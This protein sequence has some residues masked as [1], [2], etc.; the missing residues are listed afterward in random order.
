MRVAKYYGFT[1]IELIVVVAII[2]ILSTIVLASMSTSKQKAR[3]VVDLAAVQD[4]QRVAFSQANENGKYPTTND[5]CAKLR[6]VPNI[7]KVT[8]GVGLNKATWEVHL[9]W[10]N[11][12]FTCLDSAG[13]IIH[14]DT[15]ESF[16]ISLTFGTYQCG[17]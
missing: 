9:E 14:S 5:F 10:P 7:V 4:I 17:N 8:C 3:E 16:A 2:A 15:E 6:F 1:I 13:R 11:G 12:K